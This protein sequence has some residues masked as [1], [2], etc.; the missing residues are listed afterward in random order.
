M[1]ER[2]PRR[3][4][5]KQKAA[6][7]RSRGQRPRLQREPRQRSRNRRQG[8]RPQARKERNLCQRYQLQGEPHQR[9]RN[10]RQRQPYGRLQSRTPVLRA[11]VTS[12]RNGCA[13]ISVHLYSPDWIRTSAR[14]RISLRIASSITTRAYLIANKSATIYRPTRHFGRNGI[15]GLPSIP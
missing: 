13:I 4:R 3:A 7:K 10:Q 2:D 11:M 6:Q 9:P 1:R 8:R 12:A 5:R 15:F 14:R